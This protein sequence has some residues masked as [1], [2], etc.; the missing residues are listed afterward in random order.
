[1]KY[2]KISEWRVGVVPQKPQLRR[3]INKGVGNRGNRYKVNK[4]NRYGGDSSYNRYGGDSSYNWY[5]KYNG[6]HGYNRESAYER[7]TR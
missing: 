6:Y 2:I 4:Y 5:N 7:G 3:S 1:M